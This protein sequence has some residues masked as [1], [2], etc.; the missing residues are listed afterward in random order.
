[1]RGEAA[2]NNQVFEEGAL[3]FSFGERWRVEKYDEHRDYRRKIGKL[4][5]TRAV[6]F[7]GLHDAR[8]LFL[9]EVKDFRG[10]RIENKDRL[11]SGELI[12]EIGHKA[13]DTIAGLVAAH[14]TSSEPEIWESFV[15]A[16]ARRSRRL[17]I[18]N[19]PLCRI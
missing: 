5:G 8:S 19:R 2:L 9:I 11:A 7:V 10:S 13:R 3:R 18:E 6:D 17:W 15:S 16:L 12:S 4:E 14:R 1:M